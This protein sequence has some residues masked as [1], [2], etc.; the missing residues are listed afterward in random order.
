MLYDTWSPYDPM[1]GDSTEDNARRRVRLQ[2][3]QQAVRAMLPHLRQEIENPNRD[4][5][6][7]YEVMAPYFQSGRDLPMT[8][9]DLPELETL[10]RLVL[11]RAIY[12]A[13]LHTPV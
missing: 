9:A 8:P 7:V 10:C 3:D 2:R 6:S 11:E 13:R 4:M 5:N 1:E 12:D